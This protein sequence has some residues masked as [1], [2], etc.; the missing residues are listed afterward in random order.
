MRGFCAV[1]YRGDPKEGVSARH[2]AGALQELM[3]KYPVAGLDPNQASAG[4]LCSPSQL[5]PGSS[6]RAL[7]S[8]QGGLQCVSRAPEHPT[9]DAA[10]RQTCCAC[11]VCF[12]CQGA[13][14]PM[15]WE[16]PPSHHRGGSTWTLCAC[17]AIQQLSRTLQQITSS[18]HSRPCFRCLLQGPARVICVGHSLGGCACPLLPFT[19]A[20]EGTMA[21]LPA[22]GARLSLG[23]HGWGKRNSPT[24]VEDQPAMWHRFIG[25]M[26]LH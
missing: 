13:C 17:H 12:C 9:S 10:T 4:Q 21:M 8:G 5:S 3:E 20:A 24:T 18:C 19:S 11:A 22:Q 1:A 26:V 7:S 23:S 2:L 14:Q 15:T 16:S 25:S 6:C